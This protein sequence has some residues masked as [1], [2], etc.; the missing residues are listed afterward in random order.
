MGS[1]SR[2]V[3]AVLFFFDVTGATNYR[4]TLATYS[5]I[6]LRRLEEHQDGSQ[7]CMDEGIALLKLPL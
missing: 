7:S 4:S 6:I 2:G 1:R 3:T 5:D